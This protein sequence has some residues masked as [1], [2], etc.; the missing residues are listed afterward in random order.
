MAEIGRK[1]WQLALDVE[2][3]SVPSLDAPNGERVTNVVDAWPPRTTLR[4]PS[5]IDQA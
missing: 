3:G 2:S 1:E 5:R 4:N